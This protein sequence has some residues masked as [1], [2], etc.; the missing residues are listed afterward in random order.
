MIPVGTDAPQRRTPYMNYF[1]IAACVVIYLISHR[2]TSPAHPYGLAHGWARFM[3]NPRHLEMVQFVTYIFLH[4]NIMHILGNMIFLWVF[5]NQVNDRLGHLAYL[6]FFLAGGILAGCGQVLTSAHGNPTLGASGSIAAVAGLFLVLC[7]L[8]NI[9]VWFFV[10]IFEVASFWFVLAQILLF[11]VYGAFTRN[12]DV[13]H[14]AHLTGYLTGFITGIV[15][16][17]LR[18]VPRDHYDLLSLLNRYRRRAAYRQMVS[19][20]YNP[21]EKPTPP[22]AGVTRIAGPVSVA[23]PEMT[24]L[25]SLV[26]QH[27]RE[28]DLLRAAAVYRDLMEKFPD[29]RLPR[30]TLLDVANELMLEKDFKRAAGAYEMVLSFGGTGADN[31][32]IKQILGIIYARYLSDSARALQLFESIIDHI[33]DA[34]RKAFLQAEIAALKAGVAHDDERG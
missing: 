19:R 13:A 28:H 9:R 11:D 32:E 21:F 15:I 29:A 2:T 26:Q 17:F 30:D 25:S 7:P 31:D 14:W 1:L 23:N 22:A 8:V 33:H 18:L 24:R 20:G 16:L 12:D 3:L 4:A 5:G 27:R 6:F 34:Q 10:I